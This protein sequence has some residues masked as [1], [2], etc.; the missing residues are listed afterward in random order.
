MGCNSGRGEYPLTIVKVSYRIGGWE[1]VVVTAT[2]SY[3]CHGR[4]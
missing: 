2:L 3:N 1:S 4:V